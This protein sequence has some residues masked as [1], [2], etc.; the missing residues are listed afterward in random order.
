MNKQYL[1]KMEIKLARI[2][3]NFPKSKGLSSDI[4]SSFYA[5]LKHTIYYLE[6]SGFVWFSLVFGISTIVGYSMLNSFYPLNCSIS[7][8]SV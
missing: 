1:P 6:R 2:T 8:N 7:N 4:R 3:N 5:D